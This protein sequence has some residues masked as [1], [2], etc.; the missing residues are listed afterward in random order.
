VGEGLPPDQFWRQTPRL[1]AAAFKGRTDWWK[2]QHDLAT[3]QAHLTA[4]LGRV[5]KFPTLDKLLGRTAAKVPQS[6]DEMLMALQALQA[7]GA[8]MN[9]RKVS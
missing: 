4:Y 5:E 1:L 9:I 2:R 6:G 7:R 3:Q 8:P